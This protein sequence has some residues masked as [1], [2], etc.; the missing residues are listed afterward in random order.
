MGLFIKR[1]IEYE[2]YKIDPSTMIL[3]FIQQSLQFGAVL[4]AA[5]YCYTRVQLGTWRGTSATEMYSLLAGN[6]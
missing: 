2:G 1:T 6:G 3:Q 5:E 4:L